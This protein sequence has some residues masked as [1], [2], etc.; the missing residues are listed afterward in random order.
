EKPLQANLEVICRPHYRIVFW[1]RNEKLVQELVERLKSKRW[2]YPPYLGIM[3]FL[4]DVEWES[5]DVV[6]ERETEQAFIYSVLPLT[7]AMAQRID[8]SGLDA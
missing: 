8:L 3:G 7:E 5:E 1:H 6:E 2:F 4:A